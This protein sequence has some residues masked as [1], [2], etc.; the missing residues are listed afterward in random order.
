MYKRQPLRVGSAN[1]SAS[2]AFSVDNY[3]II[4]DDAIITGDIDV[5]GSIIVEL[6]DVPLSQE[7]AIYDGATVEFYQTINMQS[8]YLDM[9]KPA[10]YA[11]DSTYSNGILVN[12]NV[13]GQY[14]KSVVKLQTRFGLSADDVTI[15]ELKVTANSTGHPTVVRLLSFLDVINLQ[16]SLIHI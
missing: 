13:E 6:I 5:A 8:N 10:N 11:L 16:L 3:P 9:V 2:T 1:I 4:V 15:S 14:A 7:V 12:N